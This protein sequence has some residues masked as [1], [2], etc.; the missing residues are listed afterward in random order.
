MTKKPAKSNP[1]DEDIGTGGAV[2]LA[3]LFT[4]II[5]GI[6]TLAIAMDVAER[7]CKIDAAI[8]EA[9]QQPAV[10]RIIKGRCE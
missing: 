7:Q 8:V 4:V 1:L 2:M 9:A 10:A 5:M 3:V 6:L